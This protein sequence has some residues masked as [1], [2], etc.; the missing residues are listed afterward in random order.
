MNFIFKTS[1]PVAPLL[2][3]FVD[4]HCHL[5]PG[6][7]DGAKDLDHALQLIE[8]IKSLGLGG[9]IATP[10]VMKDTYPNTQKTI[11]K[12]S[13]LLIKALKEKEDQDLFIASAA[14]H[15]LD[16]D[17]EGHLKSKQVFPILDEYMLVE[18]SYYMPPDN[19]ETLIFET[20]SAGYKAI[21]AHPERYN[22][23]E[24]TK[25]YVKLK[26]SGLLFQ[27][28]L[29][30]LSKQ[31]GPHVQKKA[32]KMLKAGLYDFVGTDIHH[33]KHIEK[34]HK[35]QIPSSHYPYL[36]ELLEKNHIFKP[37]QV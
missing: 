35:L 19:F 3:G 7:D 30:S 17:Y 18:M 36:K 28:N 9:F 10:H 11:S 26:N 25:D 14:E 31:Y 15:M 24:S 23:I 1:K 4:I 20:L 37:E 16:E 2:K 34:L 12:A 5:I 8:G 29:L 6:I 22:F 32:L 13:D 21:L 27:L 33:M